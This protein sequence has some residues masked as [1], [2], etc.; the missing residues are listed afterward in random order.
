MSKQVF[1]A[2][3]WGGTGRFQ[4]QRQDKGQ[5]FEVPLGHHITSPGDA[6]VIAWASDGPF[7]NGFG[8]PYAIVRV[9][10]GRFAVGNGEWYCGH[11]NQDVAPVGTKLKLGDPIARANNS[12]HAGWGWC[13]LGKW[14]GG[15]HADGEGARWAHLFTPL[16]VQ[17]PFRPI[18]KGSRGP[19]VVRITKRLAYIRKAGGHPY[20]TRWFWRYKDPV[21]E[22]VRA[23]QKSHKL[24]V[25]GEID[26]ATDAEINR[27]FKHQWSRRGK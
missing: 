16:V 13:E 24:K 11:A 1:N 21:V 4:M 17:T 20:L 23:F 14:D 8:S 27:I 12:L 25:T 2:G 5:D 22:V 19:R 9:D 18:R 7:P 3:G 6:E 15:P 26:G 10:S